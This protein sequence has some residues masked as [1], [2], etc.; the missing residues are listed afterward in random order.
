[1]TL[2]GH[3]EGERLLRIGLTGGIGSGKSAVAELL[4]QQG[5][6]VIDTDVIAHQLTGPG[7]AAIEPLR[8]AFGDGIIAADG[9]MDRVRMRE[10]V[11]HDGTA[12]ARLEALLH[13]MI[14]EAARK[15]ALAAGGCYQVF[16][17]PLLVEGGDRWRKRVDRVCVVDCDE[18][19][20]AQRV[21]QR[22]GLAPDLIARIMAA[23]ATRAERLAMADDVILNDGATTREQL[24]A[25]TLAQHRDWMTRRHI[26]KPHR[27]N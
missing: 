21:A 22:S 13:P 15:Q 23:Q 9:A 10:L 4:A 5:A 19:S 16:V 27:Q 17:V 8:Q 7:G 20:Q 2:A 25:R 3:D 18:A 11:F 26:S 6:A 12:K 14:G 24:A 1:M